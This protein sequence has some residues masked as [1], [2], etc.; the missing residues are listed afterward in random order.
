MN[1]E[2]I[3]LRL[4]HIV[5]GVVWAGWAVSLWLFVE[6]AT[7]DMGPAGGMFMQ[8]LTGKTPL[9]KVMTIAPLL[10]II[11]GFRLLWISSGGFDGA[12]ITTTQ[13]ATL[14]TGSILGTL[15]FVYGMLV[16]RPAGTK[17]GVIAKQIQASGQPPSQ[18]QVAQINSL[19]ETLKSGGKI[20]AILLLV[21]V[22]LMSVA[23]F[24]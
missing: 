5:L 6:P 19:R 21:T 4:L 12:W 17:M 1:V 10:V 9:I 8:N 7:R 16:M 15:V 11:A 18:E 23:R 2:I 24:M 14:T 22:A 20:A 13:G 3:V